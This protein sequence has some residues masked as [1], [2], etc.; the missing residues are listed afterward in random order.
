MKVRRVLVRLQRDRDLDAALAIL[1][2]R[3]NASYEPLVDEVGEGFLGALL[4]ADGDGGARQSR[5]HQICVC[6]RAFWAS[7]TMPLGNSA[8]AAYSS[9]AASRMSAPS[10]LARNFSVVR[11]PCWQE[12]ASS[13]RSASLFASSATRL[14]S[15]EVMSSEGT[16]IL[17]PSS[18][19]AAK[20]KPVADVSTRGA[21]RGMLRERPAAR[22][23]RRRYSFEQVGATRVSAEIE[24][25]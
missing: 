7:R 10:G 20:E 24:P 8:P 6:S 17:A 14:S 13:V 19:P 4:E 21:L 15:G 23:L 3:S 11:R 1:H 12:R 5:A 18:K 16:A 9:V 22:R 2:G 25:V